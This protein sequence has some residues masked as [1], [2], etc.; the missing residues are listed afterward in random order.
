MI[1]LVIVGLLGSKVVGLLERAS[2][3]GA[4]GFTRV[5]KPA[6]EFTIPRLDGGELDLSQHR[7]RPLVINFR[8]S[9]CPPCREGTPP[10]ERNWR[11]YKDQG[12][13]SVGVDIQ[14]LRRTAESISGHLISPTPTAWTGTAG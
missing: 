8:A 12:A 10:L 2:V 7:G 14:E 9:W 5:Q 6:R 1:G 3:T 11:S 13:L 4:S